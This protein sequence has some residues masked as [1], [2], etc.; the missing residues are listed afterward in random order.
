MIA[1]IN[2]LKSILWLTLLYIAVRLLSNLHISVLGISGYHT[3]WIGLILWVTPIIILVL[4]IV[5]LWAFIQSF[6]ATFREHASTVRRTWY[7]VRD[8]NN[9]R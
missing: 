9:R 2:R 8:W 7:K 5:G 1:I 3:W 6:I 4:A